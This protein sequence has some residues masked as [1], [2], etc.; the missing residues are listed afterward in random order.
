M[1]WMTANEAAA[2]LKIDSRTII[3]W[4]KQGKIKGYVLSGSERITWRFLQS[5][6]DS[7][8]TAPVVLEKDAA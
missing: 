5:D 2:Y 8:M 6:L 7:I 4:A 3:R 1:N